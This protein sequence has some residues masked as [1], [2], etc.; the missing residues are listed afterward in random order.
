M[1]P[2]QAAGEAKEKE[3]VLS[4]D[5]PT[6]EGLA[7]RFETAEVEVDVEVERYQGLRESKRETVKEKRVEVEPTDG[8]VVRA[9]DSQRS[10]AVRGCDLMKLQPST[11]VDVESSR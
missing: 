2:E 1:L 4:G 9:D 10:E 5:A 8:F 11:L 7:M 3:R 6:S